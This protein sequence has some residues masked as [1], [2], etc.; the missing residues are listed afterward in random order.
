M[1]CGC[2]DG[3]QPKAPPQPP[4]D[5]AAVAARNAELTELRRL[6]L[7]NQKAEEQRRL[8]ERQSA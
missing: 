5:M 7:E 8:A 6:N 2:K 4:P 1:A 3:N